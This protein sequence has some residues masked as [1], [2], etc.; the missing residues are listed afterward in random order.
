MINQV[1]A[2]IPRVCRG[3]S[4]AESRTTTSISYVA[5]DVFGEKFGDIPHGAFVRDEF[6]HGRRVSG[7]FIRLPRPKV[8]SCRYV[9]YVTIEISTSQAGRE[10]SFTCEYTRYRMDRIMGNL[11]YLLWKTQLC[12]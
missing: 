6:L 2:M 10:W 7:S 12:S 8:R 5:A 3:A 11:T 9:I 4:I 1:M